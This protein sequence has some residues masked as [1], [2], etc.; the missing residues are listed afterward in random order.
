[1]NRLK[2]TAAMLGLLTPCFAPSVRADERNKETRVTTKQ[3]LQVQDT[4]LPPGQY[5]FKLLEPDTDENV[6]SIFNADGGRLEGIVIGTSAYRSNAGD[7]ELLTVSQ[8]VGEQPAR[9]KSWFF[10][11]DNVGIDFR[12]TKPATGDARLA[13][14]KGKGQNTGV[15][16][17]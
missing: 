17:G 3:P 12:V 11:G 16:G 10:P 13:K 1:M 9:L 2:I 4:V 5:L 8:P 6:V 7:K 14:S 15:A